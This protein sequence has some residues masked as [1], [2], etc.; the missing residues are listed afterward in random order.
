MKASLERC[1]PISLPGNTWGG[2]FNHLA[3]LEHESHLLRGELARP[4]SLLLHVLPGVK[5]QL[6]VRK[7]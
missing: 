7:G 6:E 1:H 4:H 5:Q 3:G 2:S